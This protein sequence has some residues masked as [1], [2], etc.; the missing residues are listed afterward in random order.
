MRICRTS[1]IVNISLAFLE[2]THVKCFTRLDCHA[3]TLL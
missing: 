1:R 2:L 3:Q